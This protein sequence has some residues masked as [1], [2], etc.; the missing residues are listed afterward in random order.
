MDPV[1]IDAAHSLVVVR[2]NI[3]HQRRALKN[4]ETNNHYVIFIDERYNKTYCKSP[5]PQNICSFVKN[6]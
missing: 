1:D 4:T 6:E 3:W 2:I 5:I